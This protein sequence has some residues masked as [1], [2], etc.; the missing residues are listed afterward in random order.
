MKVRTFAVFG[1]GYVLGTKAGR[2]RYGQIIAAAQNA[3]KR[4]EE[5]SD[6]FDSFAGKFDSFRGRLDGLKTKL[7]DYSA[8]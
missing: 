2:E 4:L 1:A 7:Q 8:E 6:K 3:P 5:Y